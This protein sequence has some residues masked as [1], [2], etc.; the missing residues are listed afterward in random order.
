MLKICQK[1]KKREREY[2]AF[3]HLSGQKQTNKNKNKESTY[4]FITEI[5]ASKSVKPV[6]I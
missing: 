6:A 5:E 4:M 3:W 1:K 2:K